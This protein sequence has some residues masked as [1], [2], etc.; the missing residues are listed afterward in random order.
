MKKILIII[1]AVFISSSVFAS[2]A[3]YFDDEYYIEDLDVSLA[4]EAKLEKGGFFFNISFSPGTAAPAD[5]YD[6]INGY[7][8]SNPS[9]YVKLLGIDGELLDYYEIPI[10]QFYNMQDIEDGRVV[11]EY[12]ANHAISPLIADKLASVELDYLSDGKDYRTESSDITVPED[13]RGYWLVN[14]YNEYIVI[15]ADDIILNGQP[16]MHDFATAVAAGASVSLSEEREQNRYLLN[17]RMFS[18]GK[19]LYVAFLLLLDG[20]EMTFMINEDGYESEGQLTR[21]F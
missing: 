9:V 4:L 2:D 14:G 3:L 12:M 10:I 5:L 13:F 6:L 8:L 16:F 11:Y 17:I 21:I 19:S 18:R 1:F 20:D 7:Y 15:T